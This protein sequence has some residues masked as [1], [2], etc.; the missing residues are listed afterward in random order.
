M[1]IKEKEIQNAYTFKTEVKQLLKILVHSLYKDRE[2]FL[3]ELIS[4]ASDALTRLHFE[5]LTNRE[6]LDQDAELAIYITVPEVG[7]D[8]PKKIIIKDTGIGMNRDELMQNLGTIAQSGAREFLATIEKGQIDPSEV[9]GQFGVG[10]YS[11]FMVADEVR[12]VSRSF[13]PE[14]EAAAWVSDGSES[15]RIEPAEK[16]DRGTEI[17]IQ[18]KKDAEEF[19]SEWKLRQIIKKHSDFVRYPIY[20]GEEQANQQTSLWRKSPSDVKE[21]DHKNFYRQMSMDFEDP[22]LTIH[23][24]SD[25]PVNVRALL[26]VPAKRERGFLSARKEPGVMLYSHNVLIQEYCTDLLPQWLNFV[27]GVVDSEDLPLNVSRETVQ[28]NRLMRQLAKTIKGRVL[29]EL[30]K[31]AED[32]PEKYEQFWAEY[33]RIFKE[34]IAVDPLA[35]EDVLPFLRYQTSKSDG[36]LRSLD[37]I[38]VDMGDD[39]KEIYYVL[40]DDLQAAAISPHLDPFKA[41]DI[42]VMFWVD[43]LDALIAP[44]MDAY[45]EKKFRS[46]D[47]AELE[48]PELD[49]EKKEEEPENRLDDP[50]FN[51]FVGRCVTTLGDRVTEVRE[52][53][54]LKDSPVRL[55]SPKDATGH[56]MARLNK[57]L[58]RDFEVPKKILEVNRNHPLVMRVARLIAENSDSEVINLTIEQLYESA[59]MQEGLH[60]NPAA[61]LPRIQK[62][63]EL[64]AKVED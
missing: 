14:D 43:P 13:R 25:A 18:L 55:V 16:S 35:K 21:E 36:K 62:L 4:N 38:I 61:M 64:A 12:V 1:T 53:K 11:V 8:E 24:S 58:G 63:M 41:R 48:L 47:E 51:R 2:I 56:E 15:F 7:E 52:S 45:K 3:R 28:N 17:H 10:F 39:Q 49:A 59:L 30:K 33:G 20:V 54:V 44:V 34:A 31:L 26:F 40:A 29:R 27:D 46:I 19:A 32:S 37:D 23:F 5:T 42:E 57:L 9:I 6:I 22:L 60:P 50:D